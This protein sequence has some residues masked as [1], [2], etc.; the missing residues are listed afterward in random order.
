M[1]LKDRDIPKWLVEKDLWLRAKYTGDTTVNAVHRAIDYY[2]EDI[3]FHWYF[4]HNH[5]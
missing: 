2:V 1:Q 3:A 4:W 5:A